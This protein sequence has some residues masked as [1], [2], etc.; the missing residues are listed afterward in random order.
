MRTSLIALSV[1]TASGAASAQSSV[2]LFG[3]LDAGISHYEN[4]SIFYSGNPFAVPPLVVPSGATRSKWALSNSGISASKLGFRGSED[5]GGGLA[6]G[7]WI[8]ES[9]A[10]DTGLGVGPGGTIIFNRRSTVS[11]SGGFGEIR[12]GRDYVPTYWNNANFDP[13]VNLGVGASLFTLIGNNLSATRGPGST[14][15]ASDNYV[16]TGNSIGYFLPDSLGGFYGQAMY[17]FHENIKTSGTVDSPSKTGRY[18]GA[19]FGYLKGPLDVAISYGTSQ[20]V[21][22]PVGANLVD[23]KITEFNLGAS[24]DFGPV[25]LFGEIM[26]MKDKREVLSVAGVSTQTSDKYK[27]GLVGLTVPIGP[28]LI[29]A[30]YA[31]VKFDNGIIAAPGLIA[32][33][34]DA[35][36]QKL[37]LGYVHNLSKRTALY[38]TVAK[39]KIKDGQNNPAIMGTAIAPGTGVTYL[40]TGAGV[41]G[42][43]PRSSTGYDFGIRHAF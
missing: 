18:Y 1:L 38:A 32:L 16:R 28:G 6:A 2:S 30:T 35:S 10:N 26:Q 40:S 12:L 11:L 17:S 13:F 25:K 8:E 36:S 23:N 5:L 22:G 4:K 43:A 20:A 3:T 27:G 14:V 37:A 33:N 19:R 24:Y 41:T 9:I 15:S 34:N 39:L 42:Y 21:D 7:F 29:R 31:K